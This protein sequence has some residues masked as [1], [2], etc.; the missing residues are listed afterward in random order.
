MV[1]LLLAKDD[2]D[3]DSK[4]DD[5]LTPLSW[6][7]WSGYEHWSVAA[8]HRERRSRL[9]NNR[10]QTPLSLAAERGHEVVVKLLLSEDDVDPESK[11]K[12]GRTPLSRAAGAERDGNKAAVRPKVGLPGLHGPLRSDAAI[13]GRSEC[14]EAYE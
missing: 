3:P 1:K 5:G 13:E 4:D 12:D 14:V 9:R 10:G 6:A 8:C 2:V 7:A 11:D